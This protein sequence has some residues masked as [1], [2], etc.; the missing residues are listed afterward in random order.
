MSD[1]SS[2]CE[3]EGNDGNDDNDDND[4]DD[5]HTNRDGHCQLLIA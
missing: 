3:S 4:D 1:E 2:A 5:D